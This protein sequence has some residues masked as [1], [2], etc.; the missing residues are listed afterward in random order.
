M[1]K[2]KLEQVYKDRYINV[3][4]PLA[5][6]LEELIN[7]LINKKKEKE[8]LRID[9]IRVRAKEPASFIK[10]SQSKNDD[11]TDKYS[12]PINQIYDQLG[13]RII[14]YYLYDVEKLSDFVKDYFSPVEEIYKIPESE[15]EFDYIG[16][17]FIFLIPSD[18]DNKDISKYNPPNFFELQIHT[19]FQHAWGEANHNIAYKPIK[20]LTKEQKRLIAY[21]SALS[22]GADQI[23]NDL[24]SELF[25]NN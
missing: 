4:I 7:T 21:T 1:V 24:F 6:S 23:F 15:K 17:H 25:K 14:T 12:D 19:L 13:A 9:Q 11:G 10:K 8:S 18:L 5:K 22:W 2:K 3:L 16:K 20:Q